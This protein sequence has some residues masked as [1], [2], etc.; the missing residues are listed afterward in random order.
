MLGPQIGVPVSPALPLNVPREHT[1]GEDELR[2]QRCTECDTANFVQTDT[3]RSCSS[4]ALRWAATAG[5]GSVYSW[6]V[7]HRPLGP[8]FVGPYAVAIVDLDEGYRLL[9]H[10]VDVDPGDIHQGMRVRTDPRPTGAGEERILPCFMPDVV[11]R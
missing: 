10:L 2:Y 8:G 11:P 5:R 1:A 9:T 4:H 3:C 7:V 6:T